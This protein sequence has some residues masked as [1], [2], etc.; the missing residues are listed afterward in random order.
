MWA[1]ENS[2]AHWSAFTS[3]PERLFRLLLQKVVITH[4]LKTVTLGTLIYYGIILFGLFLSASHVECNN[5]NGFS[6]QIL[7]QADPL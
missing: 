3:G 7:F 2:T 6:C 5:R 1:A 4:Y